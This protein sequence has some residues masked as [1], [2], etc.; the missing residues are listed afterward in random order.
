MKQLLHKTS[1]WHQLVPL[2]GLSG[3]L[4]SLEASEVTCGLEEDDLVVCQDEELLS[5][6]E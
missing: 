1:F 6:T 3:S 5:S 4:L 2:L